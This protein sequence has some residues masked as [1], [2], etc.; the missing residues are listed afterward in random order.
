M[1]VQFQSCPRSQR[2]RSSLFITAQFC[3]ALRSG[4]Y[5]GL[6]SSSGAHHSAAPSHAPTQSV[7]NSLICPFTCTVESSPDTLL[8]HCSKYVGSPLIPK[9]QSSSKTRTCVSLLI[10][11]YPRYPQKKLRDDACTAPNP[12]NRGRH[13]VILSSVGKKSLIDLQKTLETFRKP[14][15]GNSALAHV[16]ER[17]RGASILRG[18]RQPDLHRSAENESAVEKN[19]VVVVSGSANGVIRTL[20]LPCA[21]QTISMTIHPYGQT[22]SDSGTQ[23]HGTLEVRRAAGW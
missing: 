23:C 1:S 8:W 9:Y 5:E 12:L 19:S 20:T 7:N 22:R 2:A 17:P 3:R 14:E 4:R 6:T 10:S 21:P 15:A 16:S 13:N 11:S 18:G